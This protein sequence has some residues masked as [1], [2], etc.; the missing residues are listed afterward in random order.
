MAGLQPGITR[1][2]DSDRLSEKGTT[3]FHGIPCYPPGDRRA[4]AG[5]YHTA[6]RRGRRLSL[7]GRSRRRP[8]QRYRA[9]RGQSGRAD[10]YRRPQP[11]EL[12]SGSRPLL[13]QEPGGTHPRDP[14]TPR[15][16]SRATSRGASRP[17]RRTVGHLPAFLRLSVSCTRLPSAGPARF[18]PG[19]PG[20]DDPTPAEYTR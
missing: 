6:R 20:T 12:R 5:G 14:V 13:D 16:T 11:G 7:D 19:P 10:S 3:R 2:V 17:G 8:L 15:G 4:G 1:L 18:P 9:C